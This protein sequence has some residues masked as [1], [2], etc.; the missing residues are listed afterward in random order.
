V[1][2]AA[3]LIRDGKMPGAHIHIF[4]KASLLGGSL[5]GASQ[6]ACT[7]PSSAPWPLSVPSWKQANASQ[8]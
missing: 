3:F 7:L 4:E 2:A 8:H 6:S 1:A 5:D